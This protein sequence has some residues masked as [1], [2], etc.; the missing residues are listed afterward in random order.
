VIAIPKTASVARLQENAKAL[1]HPLDAAA[2]AELDTLFPP[3]KGPVPLE[4][5]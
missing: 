4:T 1:A 2:L 5:L 3:P